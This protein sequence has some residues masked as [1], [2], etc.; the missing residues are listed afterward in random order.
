M[1]S[2]CQSLIASIIS[3]LRYGLIVSTIDLV[4]QS[5]SE[6]IEETNNYKAVHEQ[7]TPI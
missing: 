4:D 5:V 1:S 3:S 2:H 6:L 7:H